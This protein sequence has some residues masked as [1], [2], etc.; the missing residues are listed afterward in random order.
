MLKG[1]EAMIDVQRQI[2]DIM[3]MVEETNTT[4]VEMEGSILEASI[5]NRLINA[6]NITEVSEDLRYLVQSDMESRIFQIQRILANKL[7]AYK[8]KRNSYVD[9]NIW[10]IQDLYKEEVVKK[11]EERI[12]EKE[13][14]L[15]KLSRSK[16]IDL[17]FLY[18]LFSF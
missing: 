3:K 10:E 7:D 9:D 12:K 1:I 8:G 15:I 5:N 16:I 13:V 2:K 4:I 6:T 11:E 14:I 17:V 18:F